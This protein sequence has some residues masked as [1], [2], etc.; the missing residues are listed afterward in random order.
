M[1]VPSPPLRF[2]LSK[3]F[4]S[5]IPFFRNLPDGC[6]ATLLYLAVWVAF[7][8]LLLLRDFSPGNELRY[9]SLAED[10][11][12]EKTFF[13]FDLNGVA[14][15]DKPP[16]FFWLLI[17][18][19][20]V[21]GPHYMQAAP[22]LSLL[23]AFGI[24]EIMRRWLRDEIQ[25]DGKQCFTG[26][27]ATLILLTS[28]LYIALAG[29][30]RMDMLMC[31]FITLAFR[32]FWL[33]LHRPTRMRR[34]TFPLFVFLALFSK[35][36]I[37]LLLPFVA[38]TAYLVSSKQMRTFRVFWGWRTWLLLGLCCTAWFLSVYNEGGLEYLRNLLFHQTFDRAVDSF[39]HKEPF[40]FYLKGVWYGFAPWS[41]LLAA[42]FCFALRRRFA[43]Q[44][45]ERFF[46]VIVI[47]GFI[48]FSAISSKIDIYLLPLYPFI[49]FLGISFLQRYDLKS[50]LFALTLRIPTGLFLLGG[51]CLAVLS[52]AV[53]DFPFWR[54]PLFL[55]GC[56][57]ASS[58]LL[59][60][61][62][63]R[64]FRLP[65][66]VRRLAAG[67]LLALFLIGFITPAVNDYIGY[68]HLAAVA[69]ETARTEGIATFYAWNVPRPEG[70]DVFLTKPIRKISTEE[71]FCNPP[72][73]SVLLLKKS[74]LTAFPEYK[75]SII[76]RYAV[77]VI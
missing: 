52:V 70:M 26:F 74:D 13:T 64:N 39:H 69:R 6:K 2:R 37:G 53:P 68:A 15:A 32:T 23:P 8:P 51:I 4:S 67:M 49:V 58:G 21:F 33:Q 40:W 71:L 61:F 3:F 55:L 62:A 30:V 20:L 73:G 36:P 76:G 17:A 63:V 38:T 31:F 43:L 7:L 72:H 57:L 18:W 45:F 27:D 41:L 25:V 10:A 11:L 35:G 22:L 16:L 77:I 42:S 19:K 46:A 34:Y 14:Y 56:I 75:A 28:G 9:F 50:R 12:R 48:L 44:D 65:A 59:S 60:L 47:S 24:A 1:K 5:P 66:A 54:F 29:F